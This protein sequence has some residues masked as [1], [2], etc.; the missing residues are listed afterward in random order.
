MYESIREKEVVTRKSH[1]CCW[2]GEPIESGSI[3]YSRTYNMDGDIKSDHMHHECNVASMRVV[4][5]EGCFIEW[6]P[7]DYPRGST[8]PY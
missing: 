1:Q 7:G 2:C 6:Q 3:A 5:E 8:D 4:S